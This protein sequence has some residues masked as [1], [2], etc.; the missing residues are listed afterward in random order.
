MSTDIQSMSQKEQKACA[1]W[2]AREQVPHLKLGNEVAESLH[3]LRNQ[4]TGVL[5]E[6]LDF[7]MSKVNVFFFF[8]KWK[9]KVGQKYV[10]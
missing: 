10:I 9:H 8:F 5:A 7:H 1:P 3:F 2:G 4:N 6:I